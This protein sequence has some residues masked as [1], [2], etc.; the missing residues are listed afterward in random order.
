MNKDQSEK[1]I[2]KPNDLVICIINSRANLTIGKEYQIIDVFG[3]SST[4]IQEVW[5]KH[6]DELTLVI[7]NDN[8]EPTWY[9]HMRFVLK[10]E[11]RQHIINDILKK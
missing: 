8:G 2:Y 11:F 1:I 3:H 9:D 5:D 10:S 6:S 7:N 4:D